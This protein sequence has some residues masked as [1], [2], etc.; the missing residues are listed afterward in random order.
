MAVTPAE[1]FESAKSLAGNS[2]DEAH[3]RSCVSRLYYASYHAANNFH[4]ALSMPGYQAAKGG[5][6][7]NLIHQLNHPSIPNTEPEH[8]LSIELAQY[9]RK[10]LLNR[11]LA[12][13]RIHEGVNEKNVSTIKSHAQIIFDTIT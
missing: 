11:R 5:S 1:I 13:Y 9:L 2:G 12:D 8:D 4:N 7:E 10:G 6:H 3:Y